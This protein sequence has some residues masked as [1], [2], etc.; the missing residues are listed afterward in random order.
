MDEEAMDVLGEP[1]RVG[2]GAVMRV[3]SIAGRTGAEAFPSKYACLLEARQC[4][5]QGYLRYLRSFGD[6]GNRVKSVKLV[7]CEGQPEARNS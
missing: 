6:I 5:E 3:S 1:S 2:G 4:Q 7:S